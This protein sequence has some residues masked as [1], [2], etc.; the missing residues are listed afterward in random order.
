MA[1]TRKN[2]RGRSKSGSHRVTF[3]NVEEVQFAVQSANSDSIG[4]FNDDG[5]HSDGSYRY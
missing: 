2:T 3:S 5:V 4:G 1:E